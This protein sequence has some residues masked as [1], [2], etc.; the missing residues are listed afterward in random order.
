MVGFQERN[1]RVVLWQSITMHVTS[2][3]KGSK[4]NSNTEDIDMAKS[5]QAGR[6]GKHDGQTDACN[7]WHPKWAGPFVTHYCHCCNK[8]KLHRYKDKSTRLN[9]ATWQALRDWITLLPLTLQC[10]TLC[11]Y[12]MP[13]PTN[14]GGF[15]DTSQF[16]PGGFWFRFQ[17]ALPPIVWWVP[18]W[19]QE[20]LV[21]WE[22]PMGTI[23]NSDFEML[24]LLLHWLVLG[25]FTN[26]AHTH[27][28]CWCNNTHVHFHH[29][30]YFV[31]NIVTMVHFASIFGNIW[32]QSLLPSE[33]PTSFHTIS[34]KSPE[35]SSLENK[36]LVFSYNLQILLFQT[37]SSQGDNQPCWLESQ[38]Q[39]PC[40]DL[41][42]AKA[43]SSCCWWMGK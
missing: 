29:P 38:W 32:Y 13:T 40:A 36:S 31:Y 5:C 30:Q 25:K 42:L 39:W 17:K 15:C 22:C 24:G 19:V 14:F 21:T 1:F 34:P 11:Q 18:T 20:T 4:D 33:P 35:S 3:Q 26:L 37:I 8:I 27:V 10:P 12:L 16:G 9:V 7:N 23:S 28:V 6:T 2:H 41:I 43:A